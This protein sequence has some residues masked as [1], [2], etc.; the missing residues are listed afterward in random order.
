MFKKAVNIDLIYVELPLEERIA[1]AKRD[2]FDAVEFY[3]GWEGRDLDRIKRCLDDNQI[4]LSTMSGDVPEKFKLAMCDP[5]QRSIYLDYI[6]RSIEAAKKLGNPTLMIH[7]AAID[8]QEPY[9]ALPLSQNYSDTTKLCTMYDIL[10]TIGSW[11]EEAGVSF[12]LEPLSE[13]AH[14]GYFLQKT[15]VTADLCDAVDS[16]AVKVLYDAYH[17]YLEEGRLCETLSKYIG[18][19]GHIHIADAPGRHEPGTGAVNWR[20]VLKHIK[21]L[22]YDR[23]VSFEFYPESTSEKAIKAIHAVIDN[24]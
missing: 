21:T 3:W 16:P 9:G 18:S 1:A 8:D 20:N 17:Q 13:I 7:A 24:L 6:K 4:A 14:S 5:Q 10:K 19:I 2:G 23:Y 22:P 12:V 11:G 15:D